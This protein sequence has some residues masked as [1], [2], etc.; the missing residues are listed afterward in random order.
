MIR[1]L[2]NSQRLLFESLLLQEMSDSSP[3]LLGN[4]HKNLNEIV[5]ILNK[6]CSKVTNL[7]CRLEIP[8]HDGRLVLEHGEQQLVADHIQ[9]FIHSINSGIVR[10]IAELEME[11]TL[12]VS[13]K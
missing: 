8:P 2:R 3:L 12:H 4:V 7:I 10:L 11:F 5:F 9:I 1:I 6:L 13:T